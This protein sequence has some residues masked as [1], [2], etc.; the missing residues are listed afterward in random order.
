MWKRFTW[1]QTLMSSS[2]LPWRNENLLDTRAWCQAKVTGQRDLLDVTLSTAF[3]I[4]LWSA[5]AWWK[6]PLHQGLM[7]SQSVKEIYLTS[8]L[9]LLL[10]SSSDLPWCDEN[11]LDTSA[12]CQAKV[13]NRFASW[14]TLYFSWRQEKPDE[15]T[16]GR[17][18]VYYR[19]A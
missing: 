17:D 10:T 4:K 15:L 19:N 16:N 5:L 6:S 8:N 2:D 12:W 1:R 9:A 11:L 14:Q 18:C 7:S 13:S 3:D